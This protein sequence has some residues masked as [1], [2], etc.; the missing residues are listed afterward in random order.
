MPRSYETVITAE[1]RLRAPS[2]SSG[3]VTSP[4]GRTPPLPT[5]TVALGA[6][7]GLAAAAAAAPPRIVIS[8]VSG[9]TPVIG[10]AGRVST[11]W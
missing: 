1:R 2:T 8:P 7:C 10:S 6:A 3:T 5:R 9:I 4:P 11:T